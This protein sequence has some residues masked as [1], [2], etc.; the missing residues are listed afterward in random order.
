MAKEIPYFELKNDAQVIL[1]INRGLLPTMPECVFSSTEES[2]EE[3]LW[4]LCK[5]CWLPFPD[6]RPIMNDVTDM[7]KNAFSPPN[8]Y[9]KEE[10]LV[11]KPFERFK[12]IAIDDTYSFS[13]TYVNKSSYYLQPQPKVLEVKNSNLLA[14]K[15]PRRPREVY[16]NAARR[17]GPSLLSRELKKRGPH[18]SFKQ[19]IA[20]ADL[21]SP[22]ANDRSWRKA[23][24]KSTIAEPISSVDSCE[25][26]LTSE[27]SPL[28]SNCSLGTSISRT[29]SFES[30]DRYSAS[31]WPDILRGYDRLSR[32]SKPVDY[33]TLFQVFVRSFLWL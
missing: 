13:G 10:T 17:T 31:T 29:Q 28:L 30:L 2:A 32:R 1:A 12:S 8:A 24:R 14:F 4:G 18:L 27:P 19:Q 21:F 16:A 25:Q 23:T 5:G 26:L 7:L 15:I 33:N 20:I 11:A 6:S 9:E 3:F 22:S